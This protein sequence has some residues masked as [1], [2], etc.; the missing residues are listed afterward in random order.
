MRKGYRY[1]GPRRIS[2]CCKLL[3]LLIQVLGLLMVLIQRPEVLQ[4]L[5]LLE[6]LLMK[7]T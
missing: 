3:V 6:L 4:I 2:G 7:H 1:R 5:H